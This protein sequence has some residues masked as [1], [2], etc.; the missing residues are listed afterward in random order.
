MK[1]VTLHL[2]LEEE[3]TSLGFEAQD[4]EISPEKVALVYA[5]GSTACTCCAEVEVEHLEEIADWY[6]EEIRKAKEEAWDEGADFQFVHS[7]F[8]ST[9]GAGNNPYRKEEDAEA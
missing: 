1:E 4:K 3:L 2:N 7:P 6:A 8:P 9:A 5:L